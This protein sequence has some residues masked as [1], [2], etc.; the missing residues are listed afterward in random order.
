ML[1]AFMRCAEAAPDELA[2]AVPGT[3]DPTKHT[4]GQLRERAERFAGGL[5]R[6][7]LRPG[8]RVI[9]AS[10]PSADFYALALALAGSGM[11]V[12]LIDGSMD[13]RRLMSALRSARA[14][15]VVSVGAALRRWPLLPPLLRMRRYAVDRP[16]WGVRSLEELAGE[17]AALAD[18]GDDDPLI[19]SFTSGSSGRAKGVVRTHGELRAQH[20]A[21]G[22]HFPLAPG[23]V[24]M[25]AFPAMVLH[26]LCSGV[27]T[28]IPPV[29]LRRPGAADPVALVEA[30][31]RHGVTTLSGAP[32]YLGRLADHLE[33]T[34]DRL[35]GVRRILA[36]GAPVPR[37]LC[38]RLV[39]LFPE[40]ETTVVYG[41]T[42]AEPIA[43]VAMREVVATDG[44]GHL[45]GP[46]VPEVEAQL[47]GLPER[48]E[49]ELRPGQLSAQAVPLGEV[50]VTGDGVSRQ[51]VGDPASNAA[52]KVQEAGGRVWHRTGDV[53]RIDADGR[54]WLLGRTGDLVRHR[55]RALHPL[56]LE[57]A[58]SELPGVRAAGLVAHPGAPDGEL[59][60]VAD[61]PSALTGVRSHLQGSGLDELPV[62]LVES[63]PTDARHNS[64]VDRAALARQLSD[65]RLP[66]T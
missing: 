30:V 66:R 49:R 2:M 41:A 7:G 64:K 35:P 29:D 23:D 19:I 52:R 50:L 61:G 56:A 4:F 31:R 44:D 26:N 12:V 33:A 53:A 38:S 63:I 45:V 9:L 48:L 21:L 32:A 55:D 46:P 17:P 43:H 58:V 39:E 28:V 13:R 22:R 42:E 5:R 3:P 1:A 62:R 10:P 24:D 57:A 20:E 60:V 8:D 27:V 65:R 37:R 51:Y 47:V 25:P 36:G 40:A 16:S 59:A 18:P 14:R 15:A 54:L 34:G 6:S 11:T